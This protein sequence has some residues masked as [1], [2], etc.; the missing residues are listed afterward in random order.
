M[1]PQ[2]DS[3]TRGDHELLATNCSVH[4][5]LLILERDRGEGEMRDALET[6]FQ[7]VG[8]LRAGLTYHCIRAGWPPPY[9]KSE[10][11]LVRSVGHAFVPVVTDA[12]A[13]NKSIEAKAACSCVQATA[14]D[15]VAAMERVEELVHKGSAT[16]I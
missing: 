13:I 7:M 12:R 2:Q 10:A 5:A 6:A 11:D 1:Q 16:K 15:L 9:F 4:L 14:Q 8:A 3:F